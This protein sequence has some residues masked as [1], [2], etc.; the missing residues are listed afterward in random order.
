MPG[1]MPYY[2]LV[3]AGVHPFTDRHWS[4]DGVRLIHDGAE[5]TPWQKAQRV[6]RETVAQRYLRVCRKD[7]A[8]NCGVCTDCL[9]MMGFLRATGRTGYVATLPPLADLDLL[10]AMDLSTA[11]ER[12]AIDELR[13]LLADEGGAPDVIAALDDCLNRY[14]APEHIL[15]WTMRVRAAQAELFAAQDELQ[16]ARSSL[17]WRLTRPVRWL[18]SVARGRLH[19]R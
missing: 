2:R 14:E 7:N 6:L 10:R 15:P 1:E 17:S 3:A 19:G 9:A 13:L 5:A 11:T 8:G 18:G 4:S 12:A 16:A